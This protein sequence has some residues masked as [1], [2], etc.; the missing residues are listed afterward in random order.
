MGGSRSPPTAADCYAIA[1]TLLA[2]RI[3]SPRPSGT[4]SSS[5]RRTASDLARLATRIWPHHPDLN[6]AFLDGYGPLDAT[7]T[8][9][10]HHVTALE[11][12]T[13]FAY[14][15]RTGGNHLVHLGQ[16]LLASI[17]R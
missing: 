13:R 1:R 5:E 16:H 6:A 10:L 15:L 11:A 3:T 12:V 7:D 14:G 8:A 2:P 17:R 9:V 4:P